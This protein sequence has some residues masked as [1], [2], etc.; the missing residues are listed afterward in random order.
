MLQ[1]TSVSF[2][3]KGSLIMA[4]FYYK[5]R[6]FKASTGIK[7]DPDKWSVKKKRSADAI[8]NRQMDE[9]E[10]RLLTIYNTALS[11][12][13][14]ITNDYLKEQMLQGTPKTHRPFLKCF[15]EFIEANESTYSHSTI[16]RFRVLK[17]HL[18]N[19]A[20]SKRIALTFDSFDV[21]RLD[22]FRNYL[23]AEG[24]LNNTVIKNLKSLRKF[25]F[26]TFERGYHKSDYFKRFKL[27]KE[28][29]TDIIH[30][31]EAELKILMKHKCRN[32]FEQINLDNY[33]LRCFTGL[34][35]SDLKNLKPESIHPDHI[36]LT[37]IKTKTTIR[38]PLIKQAQ[39]ILKK[40]AD[41]SF[42]VR[43]SQKEN[44]SLKQIMK[45]AGIN[46]P[47]LRVRF[48]GSKRIETSFEKWQLLTTH[49][50]RKTFVTLS[51]RR[52][53]PD[54]MIMQITGIRD[55]KTLAKYKHI[56]QDQAQEAM[57][58]AWG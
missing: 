37:T 52:G 6:T 25:L 29:K 40:Y 5:G 38:V 51:R 22:Q 57:L 23:L 56:D 55:Y 7:T 16:K 49:T 31:T 50:A 1:K 10:H 36:I 3:L 13:A 14:E 47:V 17:N 19:F 12:G 27:G 33:L 11:E 26:W 21:Y 46:T 53:M 8:T 28:D 44:D 30:L 32:Q 41:L 45:D 42:V 2:E 20:E 54:D 34:R 39:S 24:K 4:R 43:S 48:S 9:W 15:D 35:H 58:K 18:S